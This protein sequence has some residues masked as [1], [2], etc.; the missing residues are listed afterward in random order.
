MLAI[1]S[2]YPV[3]G[4]EYAILE[5]KLGKL[6]YKAA[7]VL[8]QK[9]YNN[10]FIDETE[11]I[12]QQLRIDMMRAASYY[13]RQ[14]Y[15]ESSLEIL[16]KYVED[17][18]IKSVVLALKALWGQRTRHG[19]NRQKFGPYQEAILDQLLQKVVPVNE[20][21]SPEAPLIMDQ[22]FIIYCKQIIWNSQRS[23]GKKVTKQK[24]FRTGMCSLSEYEYLASTW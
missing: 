9:N 13:K 1:T 17:G 7:W 4:S 12:V 23:M 2:N 10:N 22:K 5:Q 11:D 20:R 24:S 18:F 14:T 8:K 16:E 15:I 21:P 19:A 3:T 6:C